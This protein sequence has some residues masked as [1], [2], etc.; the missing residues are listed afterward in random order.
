MKKYTQKLV[1]EYK[2]K[3]R[4]EKGNIKNYCVHEFSHFCLVYVCEIELI[5]G[6]SIPL[7]NFFVKNSI[8]QKR[9]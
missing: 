1:V 4:V 5:L 2:K 9:M 7:T 8:K 3:L 6:E